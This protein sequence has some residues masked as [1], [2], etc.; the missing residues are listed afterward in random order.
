MIAHRLLFMQDTEM[1]NQ[2]SL[3]KEE[4]SERGNTTEKQNGNETKDN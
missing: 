1:E 3:T 2:S 4:R